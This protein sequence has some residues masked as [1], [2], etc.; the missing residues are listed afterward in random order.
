MVDPLLIDLLRGLLLLFAILLDTY[1]VRYLHSLAVNE[2][3]SDTKI[4]LKHKKLIYE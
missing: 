3:L 2:A 1:K 4:G